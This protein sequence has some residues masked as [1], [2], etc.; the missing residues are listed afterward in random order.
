[1]KKSR[2]KKTA[3]D[4]WRAIPPKHRCDLIAYMVE[5]AEMAK[6]DSR[7]FGTYSD[8]VVAANLAAVGV[9]RAALRTRPGAKEGGSGGE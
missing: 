4:K 8:D 3:A 1:M 9:L 7:L 6:R 2:P 5:E